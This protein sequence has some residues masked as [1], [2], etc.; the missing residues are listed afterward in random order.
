MT[1]EFGNLELAVELV[2][3]GVVHVSHGLLAACEFMLIAAE[4]I[5]VVVGFQSVE[6]KG[7]LKTYF[8]NI[9]AQLILIGPKRA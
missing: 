6:A 9:L 3:V 7:S 8:L 2:D 5:D 4:S 1:L